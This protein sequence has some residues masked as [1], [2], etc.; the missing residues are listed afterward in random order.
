[1]DSSKEHQKNLDKK[2][3]LKGLHFLSIPVSRNIVISCL[4]LFVSLVLVAFIQKPQ[5]LTQYAAS[6][7]QATSSASTACSPVPFY[8]LILGGGKACTR[9]TVCPTR[10]PSPGFVAISNPPKPT[11]TPTPPASSSATPACLPTPP[12][13]DK[14]IIHFDFSVFKLRTIDIPALDNYAVALKKYPKAI[15]TVAGNTDS[16][17]SQ[18]SNK[19]LSQQRAQA[20][21]DYLVRKGASTNKYIIVANGELKP[22]APNTI[23]GKDNPAGRALN[24]R[25]EITANVNPQK[26]TTPTQKLTCSNNTDNNGSGYGGYVFTP[27][28]NA[29]QVSIGSEWNVVATTCNPQAQGFSTWPGIQTN[30]MLVQAGS[31]DSCSPARYTVW[32]EAYPRPSI[33]LPAQDPVK[34][35]DHVYTSV[36]MTSKGRFTTTVKNVTRGWLYTIT[37]TDTG[38]TSIVSGIQ[39]QTG[40]LIEDQG[41]QRAQLP[42]FNPV[43]VTFNNS[44]FSINGS[45]QT[46]LAGAPGLACSNIVRSGTILDQV[47]NITGGNFTQ[48][49]KH[50]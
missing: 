25:V 14:L 30:N 4:I 10:T 16:I 1:M 29:N 6:V 9:P 40:I 26:C 33:T 31:F 46:Y 23:N 49:W 19:L 21:K 27:P 5:I 45:K 13:L 32:T 48:T 2:P 8:C 37:T 7:N 50:L 18:A 42:P 34:P 35:G 11:I 39:R 44:Q 24:R 20:V 36:T 17:D 41:T 43:N 3:F 28:A 15:V 12:S 22:I 38:Y 47:S